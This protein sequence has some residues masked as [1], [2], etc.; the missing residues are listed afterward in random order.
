MTGFITGLLKFS[1]A[2]T[3][4]SP[5]IEINPT[6]DNM[7]IIIGIIRANKFPDIIKK[8]P[9]KAFYRQILQVGQNIFIFAA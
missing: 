1:F 3:A 9:Q 5:Y 2:V 8:L 4:S 7:T 6:A